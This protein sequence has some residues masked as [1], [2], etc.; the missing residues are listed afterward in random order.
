[1]SQPDWVFFVSCFHI[2]QNVRLALM[3]LKPKISFSWNG[4]LE[5]TAEISFHDPVVVMTR[6][7]CSC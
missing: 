4:T 5:S 3:E 1:M 2:K 7:E 6:L